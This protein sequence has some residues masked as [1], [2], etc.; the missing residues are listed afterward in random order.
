M[1][2]ENNVLPT[3]IEQLKKIEGNLCPLS[4]LSMKKAFT[5]YL[6]DERHWSLSKKCDVTLRSYIIYCSFEI[7]FLPTIAGSSRSYRQRKGEDAG[8]A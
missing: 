1:A 8:G 3:I 2:L 6:S 5:N 4:E 7:P